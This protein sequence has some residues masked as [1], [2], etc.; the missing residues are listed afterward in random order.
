MHVVFIRYA[1][2]FNWTPA[3]DSGSA[4]TPPHGLIFSAF[5]F[6]GCKVQQLCSGF[7]STRLA[8]VCCMKG[9][10][11]CAGRP[12]LASSTQQCSLPRQEA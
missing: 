2:V 7:V 10:L 4:T 12:Y 11:V 8:M 9:W 3:L 1:F 5:M 6:L